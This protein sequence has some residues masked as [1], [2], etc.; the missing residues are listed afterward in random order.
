MPEYMRPLDVI[1]AAL[2]RAGYRQDGKPIPLGPSDS[3]MTPMAHATKGQGLY[4]RLYL[5]SLVHTRRACVLQR[6]DPTKLPGGPSDET[7]DA[8]GEATDPEMPSTLPS[9]S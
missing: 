1:E 7:K 3:T 8:G 4:P 9:P 2:E 6:I 5:V